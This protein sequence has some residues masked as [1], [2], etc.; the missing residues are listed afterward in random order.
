MKKAVV[1]FLALAFMMGLTCAHADP[2]DMYGQI[3]P[4][5]S[6]NTI[7]GSA[8]SLSES[9][10]THDLVLINFWATW[11]GPCCMEFPFL[12]EAWEQYSDCVDVRH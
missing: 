10:E 1:L 5:F 12:E 3:F 2:E 8:F 6:V 4:D 7:R 9:L 11:C